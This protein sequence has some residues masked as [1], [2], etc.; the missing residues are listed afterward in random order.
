MRMNYSIILKD[1]AGAPPE[2]QILP[3]GKIELDGL[4][5]VY[6]N[7]AG[8]ERIIKTFKARGNDMVIDYEH[9]TLD[10]VQAPAAGWIKQLS[11]RGKEGL[12]AAVEWTQRAK[13]YLESREYRYFS[14]VIGSTMDGLV[15]WIHNAA[16]TNSPKINNL[17]PIMAKLKMISGQNN[18]EDI[19]FE[20]LKKLLGL[21]TEAGEDKV[22]EAVEALKAKLTAVTGVLGVTEAASAADIIAAVSALKQTDIVACKEV[23]TAIGVDE[24]ASKDGAVAAITALKAMKENGGDV[25]LIQSLSTKL[26][27]VEKELAGI[28]SEKI[29]DQALKSGRTSPEELESWGRDLAEKSP[30]QFKKIVLS[31]QAGSVIPLDKIH[32]AK[33][34]LS[35]GVPDETQRE[36]NAQMGISDDTYAKYGPKTVA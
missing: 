19:M 34:S 21:P 11:W 22:P 17:K 26:A 24:S 36:I 35:G 30:D 8:A 10:D 16:L 33:G 6:L 31:R 28:Q 4:K 1:V 14:P 23:L 29:I 27:D 5:P 7:D 13:D 12:W 25:K 20:K 9:Q 32:I 18:E 15:V 2:F 3:E